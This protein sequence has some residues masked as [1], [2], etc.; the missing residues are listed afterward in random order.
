MVRPRTIQT[1]PVTRPS[2]APSPSARRPPLPADAARLTLEV[3]RRCLPVGVMVLDAD[4]RTLFTNEAG[5][6]LAALWNHGFGTL[7]CLQTR[8]P[9][10]VPDEV[11]GACGRLLGGSRR[12]GISGA[13]GRELVR[14]PRRP[15]LGALVTVQPSARPDGSALFGVV[16]QE[17][18]PAGRADAAGSAERWSVLTVSERA[19]AQLVAEGLNNCE[20][21]GRLGKSV[22]T[23]K[24]QLRAIFGKLKIARRAQLI[25]AWHGLDGRPGCVSER[26]AARLLQAGG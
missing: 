8:V 5:R 3:L 21:A 4:L 15:H 26:P 20:V 13:A 25:V 22:A 17:E 2:L 14:N 18:D 1:F 12:G 11:V 9:L 6:R 19:V 16:F 7:K 23:V 10:A 24:T